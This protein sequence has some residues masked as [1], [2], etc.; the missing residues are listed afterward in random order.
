MLKGTIKWFSQTIGGGFIRSDDGRDIF[1]PVSA[2]RERD[3][4][5]P[6]K[7]QVVSFDLLKRR[8]AISLAASNVKTL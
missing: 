3:K 2:L 8:R 7:G 1:F 5:A 4:Q 6:Q